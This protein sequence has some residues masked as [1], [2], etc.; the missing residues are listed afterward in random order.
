MTERE[1]GYT[2]ALSDVQVE[3][4]RMVQ[5]PSTSSKGKLELLGVLSFLSELVDTNVL[6]YSRSGEATHAK[7]TSRNVKG[8]LRGAGGRTR[9]T[10]SRA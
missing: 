7:R 8:D 3:V 4:R 2:H 9:S 5:D 6:R 10:R 1:A